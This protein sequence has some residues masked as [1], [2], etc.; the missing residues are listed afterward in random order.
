MPAAGP[1]VADRLDANKIVCH[2]LNHG[3]I[4]WDD[5]AALDFSV[6]DREQFS[7]LIGYSLSGFGELSYVRN[8]TY[9]AAAKM[10]EFGLSETQARIAHLEGELLRRAEYKD[11][12]FPLIGNQMQMPPIM[13]AFS[14]L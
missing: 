14:Y 6:E 3:G 10:A 5:L 9:E 7:Q 12:V 11:V 1:R 2:L 8:D 4:T 13:A